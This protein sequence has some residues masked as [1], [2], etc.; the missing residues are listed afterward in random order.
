[1][2][3]EKNILK[4]WQKPLYGLLGT[5]LIIGSLT[6]SYLGLSFMENGV[7]STNDIYFVFSSFAFILLFI[8]TI[9]FTLPYYIVNKYKNTQEGIKV[10]LYQLFFSFMINML[11]LIFSSTAVN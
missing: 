1:M 7:R 10:F 3:Q 4:T 6:I 11:L 8:L 9:T 5:I 2:E